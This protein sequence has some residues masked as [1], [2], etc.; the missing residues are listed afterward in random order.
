[1]NSRLNAVSIL[2]LFFFNACNSMPSSLSHLD[3][4][5]RR[6]A[7]PPLFLQ[8]TSLF[9]AL[10]SMNVTPGWDGTSANC[11]SFQKAGAMVAWEWG[12]SGGGPADPSVG[13]SLTDTQEPYIDSIVISSSIGCNGV[14]PSTLSLPLL[15]MLIITNCKMNRIQI[16]W[17]ILS[18]YNRQLR[19]LFLVELG[20]VGQIT[21]DVGRLALL[22]NLDLTGNFLSGSI[23]D[24]IGSLTSLKRLSLSDN[25]LSGQIPTSLMKLPNL[26]SLKLSLNHFSGAV[27]DTDPINQLLVCDMDG[28]N[29]TLC[30]ESESKV[31][32]ICTQPNYQSLP[33][34]MPNGSAIKQGTVVATNSGS[35][36]LPIALGSSALVLSLVLLLIVLRRYYQKYGRYPSPISLN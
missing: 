5:P 8:C 33:T 20:L 35:S 16:P 25:I 30:V 14:F 22:E 24:E 23:P 3:A 31:A 29:G 28:Q 10:Q 7:T 12:L 1:M 34:C 19:V 26:V 9:N 4:L 21:P 13:C 18:N 27:P 2:I 32:S 11:C 17:F 36:V 15:Q 6:S